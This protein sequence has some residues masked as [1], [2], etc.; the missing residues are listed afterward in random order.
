M[1]LQAEAVIPNAAELAAFHRRYADLLDR[2]N[3]A[4]SYAYLKFVSRMT[5]LELRVCLLWQDFQRR[6]NVPDVSEVH[7]PS[8]HP[9]D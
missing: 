6:H 8:V 4:Q 9:H 2:L 3:R 1:E 5:Q 7:H